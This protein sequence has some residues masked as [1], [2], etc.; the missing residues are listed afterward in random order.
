M[1]NFIPNW[2]RL[3]LTSQKE[4]VTYLLATLLKKRTQ[5]LDAG[6]GGE[7]KGKDHSHG[8]IPD[9]YYTTFVLGN[10]TLTLDKRGLREEN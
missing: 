1:S 2:K 7:Y 4:A 9:L 3:G 5:I 8:I 6:M 10:R